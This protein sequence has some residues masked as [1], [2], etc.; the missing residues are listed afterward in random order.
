MTLLSQRKSTKSFP[1]MMKVCVIGAGPCGI[2]ALAE[3][4]KVPDVELVYYEKQDLPGGL[5]NYSWMTGV[6]GH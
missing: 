5:W 4:K 1:E 3:L 6:D 2:N